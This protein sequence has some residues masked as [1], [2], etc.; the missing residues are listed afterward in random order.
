MIYTVTLNPAIDKVLFLDNLQRSKTNRLD[1]TIE[2]IGGK[3]THVSINLH[4]LGV[5]NTALGIAL[6]ENGKK[7]IQ[8]LRSMGVE[9]QFL[10][11]QIEG[12]ESRTN[13]E[14]VETS[15]PN[16]TMLTEKGPILPK[17]I[18]DDLSNQIGELVKDGDSLVLTGDAGNVEDRAIYSH[19]ARLAKRNGARVFLDA[20]GNYLNEGLESCPFLIKPNLEELSFIAGK[21]LISIDEII[22]AIREL[23]RFNIPVIA[24]TWS[25]NGAIVKYQDEY[26][27]VHPVEVN[28]VNEAGCG[29]AFLA[30]IVAGIAAGDNMIDTLKTAGAVSGATAESELTVGFEPA[31]ARGLFEKVMVEKIPG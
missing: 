3:G 25:R 23:D 13:Y 26:F 6:G 8:I 24:M 20:S 12:L 28:A 22:A 30:V 31:R 15:G 1:R 5:S 29:D 4:L 2:T 18:T 10:E 7:I 14:L 11:Y 21:E 19:L 17:S 16:C 27:R 9:E